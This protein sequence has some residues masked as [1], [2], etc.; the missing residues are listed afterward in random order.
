MAMSG[1][2]LHVGANSGTHPVLPNCCADGTNTGMGNEN[3]ALCTARLQALLRA[4]AALAK[5]GSPIPWSV[6][7]HI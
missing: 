4:L 5:T 7:G 6:L 2:S 3:A 1:Q